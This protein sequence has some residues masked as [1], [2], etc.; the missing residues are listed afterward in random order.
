MTAPLLFTPLALCGVEL[1]NRIVVSPMCQYSAID[2]MANDWHL[3]HLGKFAQGG[4]GT[5]F[6]EATA[7]RADGRITHGD[8]GLWSDEQIIPLRR[9]A[10]FLVGQGSIPAI[11]L[12]H[13]GRKAST[14]RPWYG[15][16]PLGPEDAA[17]GDNSWAVVAPSPMP[18]DSGWLMPTEL[19]VA[20]LDGL[21]DAWKSATL[22]ALEA[23]FQVIEIHAAHGYLLHEFLS[24]LSNFRTDAYGGEIE[25]RMRFPLEVVEAVRCVLP[26]DLPLFVR[27]S[28]I[29]GVDG[30]WSLD[31]SGV[32]ARALK[33]RGVDVVDCSSG[34]VGGPVTAARIPRGPGF[35]VPF[36]ASVRKAADVRTMAV[37]LILDGQQA[38]DALQS[39]QAD[40]IAIG[41]EVLFNPN[42]P[43]QARA[44]LGIEG[45]E[46]WTNW[47]A[48]YGWWLE[49][50]ERILRRS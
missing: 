27:I 36:A 2:G 4:A 14:Q 9:I 28:A 41:R 33:V 35:Q 12:G 18:T 50:R 11:Q 32:F 5:V 29:D 15:N 24:P 49:R 17:R 48:Q 21:C 7:V 34:G 47:P 10:D 13:A 16:G 8:L 22:R 46:N 23:G 1:P 19:T 20:D 25:G 45:S 38:E 26:K 40:L 37:G 3:V 30:G 42:W 43:V 39:E 31:D 6:V 44:A